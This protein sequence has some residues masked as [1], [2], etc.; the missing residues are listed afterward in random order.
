MVDLPLP[1]TPYVLTDA[2]VRPVFVCRAVVLGTSALSL[3][4]TFS[5]VDVCALEKSKLSVCTV[6]SIGRGAGCLK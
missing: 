5:A 3:Q 2:P 4:T 1:D 6:E